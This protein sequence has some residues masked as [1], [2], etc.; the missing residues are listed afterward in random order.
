MV[1]YLPWLI[2]VL[3]S[4]V[5]VGGYAFSHAYVLAVARQLNNRKVFSESQILPDDIYPKRSDEVTLRG[6]RLQEATEA[7]VFY[8]RNMKPDWVV[9]VNLG[10]RML[11]VLVADA[12]GLEPT[13][14]LF[15]STDPDRDPNVVFQPSV[16]HLNCISGKMLVVDDITRTGDTFRLFRKYLNDLNFT[17]NFDL[18]VVS[19]AVVAIVAYETFFRPCPDWARFRSTSRN[20]KFPWTELSSSIQLAYSYR[21]SKRDYDQ[22][23]IDEYDRLC[24]DFQYALDIASKFLSG[25]SGIRQVTA[26]VK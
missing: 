13:K 10:G 24:S 19:F 25:R 1:F 5:V 22:S 4:C 2:P 7:M 17:K 16:D 26:A 12:I 20:L 21:H 6:S 18:S 3:L 9:G 14:C 15:V 23:V 11:S 8:A